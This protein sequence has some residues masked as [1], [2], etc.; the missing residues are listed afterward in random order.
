MTTLTPKP[1]P[2]FS[3]LAKQLPAGAHIVMHSD[4]AEPVALAKLLA[5]QAEAFRGMHL[6]TLMPMAPP[7]YAEETAAR[8]IQVETFFPGGGLRRAVNQGLA[9]ARRCN[10]SDIPQFFSG[11]EISA[12]LLL[13][14]VSR[15][16]EQGQVSLGISVDY[17]REVLAQDPIVVAQINPQMPFTLGNTRLEWADIDYAIDCEQPLLSF[18]EANADPVDTAIAQHVAAL[19]KDGDVIQAGIGALPDAVLANLGHL[20]DLGAHT[21]ILTAAWLPLIEKGVVNNRLKARFAGQCVTTM[22]GGDADFYRYLDN[23]EAIVFHPISLTHDF[24][25]LSTIDNLCAINSVLQIDLSAKANAEM[26]N[27]RLISTP[28]GLPDFSRGAMAAKGGKS[29]I[30]LRSSFKEGA[31]S[32]IVASLAADVPVSIDG[33]MISHVVTEYGVAE[34]SN[35]SGRALAEALIAIAHVDHRDTLLQAINNE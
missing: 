25:T 14:Q 12:S 34:I 17:M 10:L 35:L 3:K 6:H 22:A 26:A 29:I 18:P 9:K 15:P 4:F 19:V 21:G 24:G 30:A 1:T 32:N 13:L 28:G 8:H 5:E 11:G 7:A 31:V 23:N 2:D 16:N 33:N 27:G 20:K